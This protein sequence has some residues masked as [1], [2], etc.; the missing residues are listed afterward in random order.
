MDSD[1]DSK[2]LSFLN[3]GHI[4]NIKG[5]LLW[6]DIGFLKI[7]KTF[8]NEKLYK[9]GWNPKNKNVIENFILFQGSV[10]I[11]GYT[12]YVPSPKIKN[13]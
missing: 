13:R 4:C 11:F 2:Q 12:L 10:H 5:T 8:S 1:G 3:F 6:T 9:Q 7:F